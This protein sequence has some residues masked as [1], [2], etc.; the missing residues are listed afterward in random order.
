MHHIYLVFNVFRM[1]A[2][3]RT[4]A[5]DDKSV[6]GLLYHLSLGRSPDTAILWFL[7]LIYY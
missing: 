2:A 5:I 1:Q 6:S 3:M 7:R 4:F